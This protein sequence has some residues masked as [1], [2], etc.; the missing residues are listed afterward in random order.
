MGRERNW[1]PGEWAAALQCCQVLT[2]I[3]GHIRPKPPAI[4]EAFTATYLKNLLM[5]DISKQN[6]NKK[7]KKNIVWGG[8]L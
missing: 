1:F 7:E 5:H 6:N 8:I 2:S 4:F 3:H